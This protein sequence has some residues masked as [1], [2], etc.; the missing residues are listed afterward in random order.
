MVLLSEMPNRRRLRSRRIAAAL[1]SLLFASHRHEARTTVKSKAQPEK[2][3]RMITL[4]GFAV[5]L[6]WLVVSHSLA[7]YLADVAPKAALWLSPGE[8]EAL[9]NLADRSLNASAPV[10]ATDVADQG[11]QSQEAGA[12]TSA[13]DSAG[14]AATPTS[15]TEDNKSNSKTIV[16][17]N[18]SADSENINATFDIFGRYRSVDLATIRAE[19]ESALMNDPLNPRALRILG[20]A[21]DAAGND[22]DALM[23]MQAATRLSLHES[24]AD[25]WLMRK[26]TAAGDYKTAIAYADVLLRTNLGF[27]RFVA[28]LLAHFADKEP[29]ASVVKALLNTN[30]P[31]RS[32]FFAFL[33]EGV[34]DV[35]TPLDMLLAL[36]TNP[37]PPTSREI[38]DYLTYLIARKYYSVAYYA[39]LQLLPAEELKHVGLLYNGNFANAP[40]GL[41]FDWAITQGSGVTIDI[42]PQR[43]NNDE[44]ALSVDFL[45]GRVDYH[46]V[47]ELVL[48]A[49]GTYQFE[50][51]Y[52]GELLGPRGLK[53]R[54]A[55]VGDPNAPIAES[56]MIGGVASTWKDTKFTFT[57]PD[58]DCR[59]QYVRLDLDARM[60]SEQ[61]VTGSMLFADLNISRV[62]EAS[63]PEASDPDA[64]DPDA[65]NSQKSSE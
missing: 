58:A 33:P 20:Q 32:I 38:D 9:V 34:S 21:A 3:L 37:T 25:Y 59:A 49:P 42:V 45:Y 1:S 47:T 39:W 57:I 51:K 61:L 17:N 35:R 54:V 7:P 5:L 41:P 12:S 6:T 8:P 43:D 16:A 29:S 60:A 46:S 26:S 62:T 55:C 31:W 11:A 63:D 56:P 18:A 4:A 48:L 65:S 24:V 30:P 15:Q 28:P 23:F 36:K 2:R 53:W 14:D 13:V 22:S 52:K 40:S 64:S 19:A 44:R 10:F 27:G 50:G